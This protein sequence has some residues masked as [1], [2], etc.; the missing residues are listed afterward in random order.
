MHSDLVA[1]PSVEGSEEK[2]SILAPG[3]KTETGLRRPS[4]GAYHHPLRTPPVMADGQVHGERAFR[5]AFGEEHVLLFHVFRTPFLPEPAVRLG[6][7][8]GHDDARC[9]GIQ[10]VKEPRFERRPDRPKLGEAK[11]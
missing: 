6:G 5:G 1:P 9:C 7:A 11:R 8:S 2:G 3:K 10:A 4:P